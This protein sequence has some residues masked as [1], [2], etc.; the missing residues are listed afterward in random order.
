M[1]YDGNMR[2]GTVL[3]TLALG[4]SGGAA[5]ATSPDAPG[6]QVP[7][8]N[9]YIVI[10]NR[11]AFG[12]KP[13]PLPP[14]AEPVA[15]VAPP[16]NLFLTGISHLN[17]QKKAYLVVN[18]ANAH[19]AD[20]LAVDEGY[21]NDG[22][23]ILAIDP[24]KQTVRVR[25]SGNE[26]TLNFK[27]NGLKPNSV[28]AGAAGPVNLPATA[29]FRGVPAPSAG[30]G[31]AGPTIIGRGGVTA[32]Q[33][34]VANA[35]AASRVASLNDAAGVTDATPQPQST[36]SRGGVYLGGGA[37]PA[38]ALGTAASDNGTS[39]LTP[40]PSVPGTLTNPRPGI[41]APP[42]PLTPNR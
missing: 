2:R 4:L 25:N 8:A 36:P 34:A 16:A 13:P 11:N 7:P 29:P 33:A 35:A 24:R 39:N 14:P 9:S 37:P 15:P 22:L 30:G 19:Q 38:A 6:S 42:L 18:K 41:V 23:Q 40:A 26:I 20:Y 27:D 17:G 10:T 12:I 3:I 1:R 21:D 5:R 31:A 28:P 32:A